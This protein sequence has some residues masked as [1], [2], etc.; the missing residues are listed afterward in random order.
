MCKEQKEYK[1]TALKETPSV[2]YFVDWFWNFIKHQSH[3]EDLLNDWLLG[4]NSSVS[5]WWVQAENLHSNQ[6]LDDI[7]AA[8]LGPHLENHCFR[9]SWTRLSEIKILSYIKSS[10]IRSKVQI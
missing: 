7:D 3:Q 5:D 1:C 2:R 4:C 9:V 10:Q 6:I 8:G